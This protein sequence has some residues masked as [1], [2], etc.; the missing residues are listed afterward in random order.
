MGDYQGVQALEEHIF[1]RFPADLAESIREDLRA[2][3]K[4]SDLT[5]TFS[6][7]RIATV[8]IGADEHLPAILVDLPSIAESVKSLDP[9]SGP[10]TTGQY[11]KVADAS[12]L[13]IVFQSTEQAA[14]FDKQLKAV[15]YQWA[16]GITPPMHQAR[17]RRFRTE[18]GRRRRAEI[19]EIE[20]QVKSL[21]EKDEISSKSTFEYYVN[22]KMVRSSVGILSTAARAEELE[23]EL[24]AEIEDEMMLVE[25]EE[26]EVEDADELEEEIL[27]PNQERLKELE[28]KRLQLEKVTNPAIRA[29]LEETI[30]QIES[31]LLQ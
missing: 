16:D 1:I 5:I 18:G 11:C 13:L 12:Q 27:D 17:L 10:A 2:V 31:E 25:E 9:G 15:D 8:H 7:P 4:P 23:A 3:R 21:M 28:A 14:A 6:S 26:E 24:A 20:E 29:F 22:D 30:K 19:E